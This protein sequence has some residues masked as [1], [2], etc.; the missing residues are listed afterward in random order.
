MLKNPNFRQEKDK[1]NYEDAEEENDTR[2]MKMDRPEEQIILDYYEYKYYDVI[3]EEYVAFAGLRRSRGKSRYMERLEPQWDNG[4]S[5]F[6]LRKDNK[7]TFKD[8][9]P[10]MKT[11]MNHNLL[12]QKN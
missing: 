9:I 3:Y 6:K 12:M 10:N 11:K 2:D 5:C 1:N 8:D 4:K 7:V